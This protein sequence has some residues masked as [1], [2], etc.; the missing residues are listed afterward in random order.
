M[1]SRKLWPGII[2]G[3]YLSAAALAWPQEPGPSSAIPTAPEAAQTQPA[4]P[5]QEPQAP[6]PNLRIIV[7]GNRRWCVRTREPIWPNK[8]VPA[9]P[10]RSRR[11]GPIVT[12]LA[13]AYYV[14]ALPES[15]ALAIEAAATPQTTPSEPPGPGSTPQTQEAGAPPQ[16]QEAAAGAA[17]GPASEGTAG[18]G[19]AQAGAPAG[20]G[21][22]LEEETLGATLQFAAPLQPPAPAAETPAPVDLAKRPG[23][24]VLTQSPVYRTMSG[25]RVQ[26]AGKPPEVKPF[27]DP[28]KSCCQFPT[29]VEAYLPPDRYIVEVNFDVFIRKRGWQ[30]VQMSRR[31]GVDIKVGEVTELTLR[32]DTDGY[33]E[34]KPAGR[35]IDFLPAP[36]AADAP[37]APAANPP[38]PAPQA[39]GSTSRTPG[40]ASA[41]APGGMH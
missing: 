35:V 17:G 4:P 10:L 37:L 31:D 7:E 6:P 14:F 24:I 41:A 29:S 22:D 40:T 18:P 3:L 16:T 36:G 21:E 32:V 13:Y 28:G 38:P 20:E 30:H 12:T 11:R 1:S 39:P 5:P 19:Q 9:P 23:T 2:A 26:L 34:V 8:T 15:E 33:V 27:W 25:R